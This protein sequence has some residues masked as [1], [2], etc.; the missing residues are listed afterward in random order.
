M[1]VTP[2]RITFAG[3]ADNRLVADDYRPTDGSGLCVLLA[4]GGGQTRHSWRGTALALAEAGFRAITIDQRGHGDSDWVAEGAYTFDDYADDLA[5]VAEALI[6]EGAGRPVVVGAS[7]GGIAGL[8]AAGESGSSLFRA[9]VL[10]DITPRVKADGVARILGFMAADAERGFASLEEAADAIS[11]YLPHRP[12]PADLSGLSKN[13]RRG[14][15]GRYRWHWDPRFLDERLDALDHARHLQSRQTE[16]ARR[17]SIPVLLVRG[18]ESELVGEEEAREFLHLVP[19]AELAD[20]SGA[21]HMVAGDRNDA[22]IGAVTSFLG[23]MAQ[24]A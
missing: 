4:H 7:L 16:A 24:L 5:A 23:R 14:A 15:D 1:A 10:V 22:F 9:L 6:D 12:R 21:R 20:V 13:L 19:Q 2:H 8:L 18:R 11:A 3:T 17:L